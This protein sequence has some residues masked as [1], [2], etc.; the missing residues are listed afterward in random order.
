M[1]STYV[2]TGAVNPEEH[3]NL[4]PALSEVVSAYPEATLTL[5]DTPVYKH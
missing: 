3:Q 4:V 5:I 2:V 1:A